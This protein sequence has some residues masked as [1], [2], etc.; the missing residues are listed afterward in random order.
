MRLLGGL[1][2]LAIIPTLGLILAGCSPTKTVSVV[3]EEGAGTWATGQHDYCI[4]KANRL[5]C[6]PQESRPLVIP[7]VLKGK[8][9]PGEKVKI[10]DVMF[11]NSV[12][13]MSQV[14]DSL[15]NRKPKL[16][17]TVFDTKF[18]EKP[19]D[20]SVWNCISTGQGSPAVECKVMKQ[21]N[22]ED[23]EYVARELKKQQE[24][25]DATLKM[26][27]LTHKLLEELCGQPLQRGEDSISVT[28]LYKGPSELLAFHFDTYPPPKDKLTIASSLEAPPAKLNH[29]AVLNGKHHW[30]GVGGL[31]SES[32]WYLQQLPCLN[33]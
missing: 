27:S 17:V 12:R 11:L 30:W 24:V 3:T 33:K 19:E 2:Q 31:E 25:K 21:P 16:H 10:E 15:E 32:P 22:S 26:S 14:E 29:D 4:Y 13:F 9:K 5:I 20:Y 1:M 6:T 23:K 18:S 8:I 28:E 7:E